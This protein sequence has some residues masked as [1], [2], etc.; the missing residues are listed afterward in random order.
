MELTYQSPSMITGGI[1]FLNP[2]IFP[3]TIAVVGTGSSKASFVRFPESE[4]QNFET[5]DDW[6][7]KLNSA[8][9]SISTNGDSVVL[10]TSLHGQVKTCYFFND[11]PDQNEWTIENSS[12]ITSSSVDKD[13]L[14]IGCEA[15]EILKFQIQF[16]NK[17]IW[18]SKNKHYVEDLSFTHDRNTFISVGKGVFLHDFR[19]QQISCFYPNDLN[20]YSCIDIHPYQEDVFITGDFSGN[21]AYWDVRAIQK[22]PIY[23]KKVH[24]DFTSDVSF[25]VKNDIFSV[26]IDG[27]TSCLTSEGQ[28]QPNFPKYQMNSLR[29]VSTSY[30]DQNSQMIVGFAQEDGLV[31]FTRHVHLKPPKFLL[32]NEVTQKD[33][34]PF[35]LNS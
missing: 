12:L 34:G 5:I 28:I 27:T 10:A 15:N 14:L 11:V 8:C 3:S 6:D 13:L 35:T 4:N 25:S 26:S 21:V 7:I 22:G 24:N 32:D 2:N 33:I 16:E 17:P 20:D 30:D 23:S 18:K 31:T 1:L 29:S 9:T 19:N